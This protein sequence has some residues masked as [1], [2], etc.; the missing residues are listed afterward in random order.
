MRLIDIQE[1]NQVRDRV[2]IQVKKQF[3]N[4]GVN[5][6]RDQGVNQVEDQVRRVIDEII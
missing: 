6:V 3:G 2:W 5:Q 4:Q 1:R